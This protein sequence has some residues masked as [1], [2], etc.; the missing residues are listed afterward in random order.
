MVAINYNI[1]LTPFV[2]TLLSVIIVVVGWWYNQSKNRINEI[3]KEARCY[4]L[5]MLSSFIDL[6]NYIEEKNKVVEPECPNEYGEQNHRFP[7]KSLWVS[8]SQQFKIYGT[9]QEG[10]LFEEILSLLIENVFC[11]N[12]LCVTDSDFDKIYNKVKELELLCVNSIRNE[13]KL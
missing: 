6:S 5:K 10:M 4:R 1:E 3:R 2:T 9:K 11:S 8:L 7:Q 12:E 13:L